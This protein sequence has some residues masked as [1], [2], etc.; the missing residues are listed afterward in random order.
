MSDEQLRLPDSVDIVLSGVAADM[1]ISREELVTL[2]LNSYIKVCRAID[3]KSIA[4]LKDGKKQM[5]D[6]AWDIAWFAFLSEVE[7]AELHQRMS[8]PSKVPFWMESRKPQEIDTPVRQMEGFEGFDFGDE[9]A[10]NAR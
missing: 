2:A 8:A 4:S 5:H 10:E 9:P 3:P 6:N 7:E 1:H